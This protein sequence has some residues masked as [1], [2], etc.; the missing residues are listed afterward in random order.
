MLDLVHRFETRFDQQLVIREDICLITDHILIDAEDHGALHDNHIPR[1]HH[2]EI[3]LIRIRDLNHKLQLG[4][5]DQIK[6]LQESI[7]V[8]RD[9]H[10]ISITSQHKI[11]RHKL[12]KPARRE[13]THIRRAILLLREESDVCLREVHAELLT[14]LRQYRYALAQQLDLLLI[15]YLETHLFL[16]FLH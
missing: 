1:L 3:T 5:I 6:A 15:F 11:W 2:L 16:I 4:V 13:V 9:L 14:L 8:A 10:P 7:P 12:A